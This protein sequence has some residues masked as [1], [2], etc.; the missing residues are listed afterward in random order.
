MKILL[1][2]DNFLIHTTM[3]KRL[4]SK[5]YKVDGFVDAKKAMKAIDEGYNCFILSLATQ[6]TQS[7]QMLQSIRDYY[8]ETPI[9][10]TNWLE[11]CELKLL[12]EAYTHGCNDFIKS[13][14]SMDEIEI[15]I[16]KL[17]HVRHD[18]VH[19]NAKCHYDFK[20]N[21]LQFGNKEK[22]FS[23]K[24]SLLFNILLTHKNSLVSFD[25]IKAVVWEGEDVSLDSIR[26]LIRRLRLKLPFNCIDTIV[27]AGYIFRYNKI[28]SNN[29]FLQEIKR[30]PHTV[31]A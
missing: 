2:E 23:R 25:A 15:K 4:S 20:T 29:L 9:I 14:F 10:M 26:S 5:G 24:E 3:I 7:L 30:S 28:N 1:L 11:E 8:P 18:V 27:D 19:L 31:S 16:D 17:C 22:H 21:M 13:P 12:K 6:T